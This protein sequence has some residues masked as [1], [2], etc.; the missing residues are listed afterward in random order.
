LGWG[1]GWLSSIVNK[2]LVLQRQHAGMEGIK[3]KDWN[4]YDLVEIL[5]PPDVT[6][7]NYLTL[8]S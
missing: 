1:D 7:V 8:L 6:Q 5:P 4:Q 2:A 3:P